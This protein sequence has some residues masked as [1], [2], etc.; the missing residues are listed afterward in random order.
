M[1]RSPT[2]RLIQSCLG[3]LLFISTARADLPKALKIGSIVQLKGKVTLVPYAPAVPVAQV[4]EKDVLQTNGTYATADRALLV[5]KLFEGTELRL[6]ADSRFSLEVDVREKVLTAFLFAGSLKVDFS[7]KANR[8]VITK[9]VL[10]SGDMVLESVD[11]KFIVVRNTLINTVS[12]TM[13]SGTATVT[14]NLGQGTPIQHLHAQE[15]LWIDLNE[16]QMPAPAKI[17]EKELKH[18]RGINKP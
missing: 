3:A 4:Q 12:A 2:R 18:L 15:M 13:E 11:G 10:K 17:T 5:A 7:S 6:S 16:Q 8:G 9:V 1:D 14:R